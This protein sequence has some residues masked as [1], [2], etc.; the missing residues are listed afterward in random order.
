MPLPAL[1]LLVPIAVRM[2][3]Q[4]AAGYAIRQALKKKGASGA[5]I[6]RAIGQARKQIADEAK[7]IK[8]AT[9][10]PKK[11]AN[12]TA[13]SNDPAKRLQQRQAQIKKDQQ[14]KKNIQGTATAVGTGLTA[15]AVGK[16]VKDSNKKTPK[17]S[18][19]DA[20]RKA[21]GKLPKK[22]SVGRNP[23]DTKKNKSNVTDADIARVK[24]K[25]AEAKLAREANNTPTPVEIA[26]AKAKQTGGAKNYNVGKSKGGVSFN[27]AFAHFRKKGNKTFTWNGKKYTTEIKK[28]KK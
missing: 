4:K 8:P 22:A 5:Q 16:A 13:T 2:L 17:A 19:S 14:K 3:G 18:M 24:R 15:G 27:E 6:T 12:S 25:T 26:R 7:K 10:K 9:V 28:G 23:F 20:Q 1:G 21:G 11:P